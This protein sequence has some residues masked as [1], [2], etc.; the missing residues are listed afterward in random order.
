MT[1]EK[2]VG[3]TDDQ[4]LCESLLAGVATAEVLFEQVGFIRSMDK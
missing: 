2:V 4:L 1:C 3:R